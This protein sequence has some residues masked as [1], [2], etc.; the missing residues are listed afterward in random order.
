MSGCIGERLK[1]TKAKS[2]RQRFR[3]KRIRIHALGNVFQGIVSRLGDQVDTAT[4][5]PRTDVDVP[6][7]RLELVPGMYA[8]GSLVLDRKHDAPAVPVQGV[9]HS[10]NQA[11]IFVVNAENKIEERP[12][13]TSIETPSNVE[14]L[15]GLNA[16]DLVV[17]G[18]HSQLQKKEV[19][20]PRVVE[21]ARAAGGK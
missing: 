21:L 6:N 13:K 2:R 9:N 12:V 17:G 19:V 16:N 18:K 11:T 20:H 14:I 1:N 15:P 3:W 7:P 5:T 4:R 8:Y 10:E